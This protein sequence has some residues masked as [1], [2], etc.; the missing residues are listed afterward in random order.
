MPLRGGSVGPYL[1]TLSVSHLTRLSLSALS[2]LELPPL[3][4]AAWV[5]C[6]S[7]PDPS[8]PHESVDSALIDHTA[9][10][11]EFETL[12]VDLPRV[13]A[14]L[15]QGFPVAQQPQASS[16]LWPRLHGDD[17]P[18]V[19][20]APFTAR[21]E[22]TFHA[23]TTLMYV[24]EM[25]GPGSSVPIARV[26]WDFSITAERDQND[27]TKRVVLASD[28]HVPDAMTTTN[29]WPEWEQNVYDFPLRRT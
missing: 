5:L 23:K 8:T 21:V 25:F 10:A 17:S 24:P 9:G 13:R 1:S 15:P 29:E 7:E 2:E 11:R 3:G 28:H 27:L 19:T 16:K 22:V 20:P 4:P 18:R 12:F 14:V 6:S 26:D